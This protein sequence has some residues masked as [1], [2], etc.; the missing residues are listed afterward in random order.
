[1]SALL[2]IHFFSLVDKKS[3]TFHKGGGGEQ[4]AREVGRKQEHLQ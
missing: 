3:F 1:M 2:L 4:R